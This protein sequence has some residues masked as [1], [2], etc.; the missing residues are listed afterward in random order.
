MSV[1]VG[2]PYCNA[3]VTLPAL[4]ADRR[5]VCDRCG[6]AF[7]ITG[8]VEAVGDPVAP[9]PV[10]A[11]RKASPA[12]VLVLLLAAVGAA[13]GGFVLAQRLN[14]PTPLP[15]PPAPP[16]GPVTWPPSVVPLLAHLPPDGAVVAAVQPGPL[17][18]HADRTGTT[19]E[20]LLAEVGVP[21]GVFAGL[22]A[23]GLPLDAIEQAV[24]GLS[25]PADSAIPRLVLAVRPKPPLT[26]SALLAKAEPD[27]TTPGRF[28]AVVGGVP[29]KAVARGGVLVAATADADLSR[30]TASG[31]GHL[32]V[33]L[34]ETLDK[35]S[36]SAFAWVAT[37]TADWADRPAVRLL[38][39]SR[40]GLPDRLRPV[41]AAAVG[42]SL[43]PAF[44]A[45]AHL[46]GDT[47]VLEDRLAAATA[48]TGATVGS[49]D[50]W[51]TVTLPP[52][53]VP[54]LLGR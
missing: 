32:P 39:L 41:R 20:K 9:R 47:G 7:P 31:S 19:A 33:G 30:P 42:L 44:R 28:R 53:A 15:P 21:A 27:P 45:T 35:L 36:P 38:A 25:L 34:R 16:A 12:A 54:G 5:A 51:V 40:P 48:G 46:R 23:V 29:V 1:R 14:T 10:A 26:P 4:P 24:A 22:T 11:D 3:R 17:A 2:C 37:D 49:A 6:E 50:G 18:A 43:E 8:E 13:V 52:A